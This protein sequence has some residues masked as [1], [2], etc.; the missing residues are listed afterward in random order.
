VKCGDTLKLVMELEE[1]RSL[2][3]QLEVIHVRT[4]KL[5]AKIISINPEDRER[6]THLLDDHVQ[7]SLSGG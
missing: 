2:T 6:V 1:G 3:C 7:S 4:P 5:G